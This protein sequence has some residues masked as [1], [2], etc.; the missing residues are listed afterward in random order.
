VPA[1]FAFF[2]ALAFAAF[3]LEAAARAGLVVAPALRAI[4]ETMARASAT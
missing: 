4:S 3:F 1:R 2:A